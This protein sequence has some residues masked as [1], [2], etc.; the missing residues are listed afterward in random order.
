MTIKHNFFNTFSD[1]RRPT[2]FGR[3]SGDMANDA[4]LLSNFK[5]ELEQQKK[6]WGLINSPGGIFDKYFA[7]RSLKK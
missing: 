2:R 4:E 6:G 3:T 5:D 1:K 7:F